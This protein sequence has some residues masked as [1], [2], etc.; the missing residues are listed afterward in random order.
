MEEFSGIKISN[1]IRHSVLTILGMFGGGEAAV[2]RHVEEQGTAQRQFLEA[3]GQEHQQLAYRWLVQQI[4]VGIVSKMPAILHVALGAGHSVWRYP[5]GRRTRIVAMEAVG[6]A[7]RIRGR[8]R[9]LALQRLQHPEH[10]HGQLGELG[11][12][13]GRAHDQDLLQAEGH[14]RRALAGRRRQRR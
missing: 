9:G 1:Y 13:A 7:Q 6:H 4:L 2:G 3:A 5:A 10:V 8:F 12:L 14:V 11:L